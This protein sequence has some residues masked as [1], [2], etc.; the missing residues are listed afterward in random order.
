MKGISSSS[1]GPSG[2][3]WSLYGMGG[4]MMYCPSEGIPKRV[5]VMCSSISSM[6]IVVM[7]VVVGAMKN[8]ADV[9]AF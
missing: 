1:D 3:G 5:V 8:M 7:V 4:P 2:M 9:H 6:V